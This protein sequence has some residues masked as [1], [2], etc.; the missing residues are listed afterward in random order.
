MGRY[1]ILEEFLHSMQFMGMPFVKDGENIQQEIESAYVNAVRTGAFD[2]EAFYDESIAGTDRVPLTDPSRR[3]EL[4]SYL[5]ERHIRRINPEYLAISAEIFYNGIVPT[6][7]PKAKN[8]Q[9]LK[10][11]DPVVY[12]LLTRYF[13]EDDWH[14]YE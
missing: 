1:L 3:Q 11:Y 9:E 7:D 4:E 6:G 12:E 14:P 8:R 2:P 13:Y 5:T 10:E